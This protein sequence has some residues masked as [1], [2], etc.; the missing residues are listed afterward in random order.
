MQ[1]GRGILE[2]EM[3]PPCEGPGRASPGSSGI[4]SQA[5]PVGVVTLEVVELVAL[6]FVL[7]GVGRERLTLAG[8]GSVWVPQPLRSEVLGAEVD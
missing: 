8:S 4:S 7:R 2:V 5:L 6:S 1:G 3:N